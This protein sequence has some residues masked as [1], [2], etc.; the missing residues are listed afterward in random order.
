MIYSLVV[1]LPLVKINIEMKFENLND[2]YFGRECDETVCFSP[3]EPKFVRPI[4]PELIED[5]VPPYY[6]FSRFRRQ[7]DYFTSLEG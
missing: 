4:I 2:C 5:Y 7:L 6:D 1:N 3:T